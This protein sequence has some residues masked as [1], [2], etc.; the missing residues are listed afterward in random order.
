M[1][2]LVSVLHLLLTEQTL[3]VLNPVGSA[4][5]TD[6]SVGQGMVTG[7]SEALGDGAATHFQEMAFSIEKVTVTA[8]SR[9][10]KA[11]TV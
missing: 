5:T 8:K 1:L 11:S 2:L 7:E 10:L 3:A 4:T 6:Y 9:A